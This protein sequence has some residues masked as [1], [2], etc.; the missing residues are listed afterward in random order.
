VPGLQASPSAAGKRPT[1]A[2]AMSASEQWELHLT[3]Q[4]AGAMR[5]TCG[6]VG[7]AYL[8]VIE[9][10][11]YASRQTLAR[12]GEGTPVAHGFSGPE[13]MVRFL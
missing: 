8:P 3:W 5:E 7:G 9:V 12:G 6:S 13:K 10:R 4:G 11:S 2:E 1:R